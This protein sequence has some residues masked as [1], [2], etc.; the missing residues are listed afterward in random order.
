VDEVRA[1]DAA[2]AV[3]AAVDA[4][5]VLELAAA[6]D[7]HPVEALAT[8]AADQALGV[9]V[10]VRRLDGCADHGDPLWKT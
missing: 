2:D 10:R 7:E 5:Y 3:M 8:D 1:L 9:C 6:E 4:K